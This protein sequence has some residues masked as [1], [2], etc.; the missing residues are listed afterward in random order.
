MRQ[1]CDRDRPRDDVHQHEHGDVGDGRAGIGP[2]DEDQHI[3]DE[4]D[5]Q[6]Y[7]DAPPPLGDILG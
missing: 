1:H 6:H 7:R 4:R 3:R 2:G 5:D